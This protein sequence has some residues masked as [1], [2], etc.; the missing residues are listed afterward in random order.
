MASPTNTVRSLPA[1]APGA[2]VAETGKLLMNKSDIARAA[3]H[4]TTKTKLLAL[5]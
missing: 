2:L 1:L 3:T 5:F 4:K